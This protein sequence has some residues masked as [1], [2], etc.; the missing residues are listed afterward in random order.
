[1]LSSAAAAADVDGDASRAN[2]GFVR[3]SQHLVQPP[4]PGTTDDDDDDHQ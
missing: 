3:W 2:P 4:P 1:M